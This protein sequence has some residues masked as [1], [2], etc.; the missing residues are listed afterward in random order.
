MVEIKFLKDLPLRH[1]NQNKTYISV[2]GGDIYYDK[3]GNRYA[4]IT[5]KNHRRSPLFALQISYREYSGEGKLIKDGEFYAPYMFETYGEFVNETPIPIDPQTEAL[6]VYVNKAIFDRDRFDN[7]RLKPFKEIDYIQE[8]KQAPKKRWDSK[9]DFDFG[10]VASTP[11]PQE[12]PQQE[13]VKEEEPKVPFSEELKIT[14]EEVIPSEPVA[15]EALVG[16]DAP[17]K[18]EEAAP[19]NATRG[20]FKPTKTWLYLIPVGIIVVVA[21]VAIVVSTMVTK[22]A[23]ENFNNTLPE[24]YFDIAKFIR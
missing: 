1:V 2:L 8:P 11:R 10:K 6:E 17:A 19:V 23:V 22:G 7:D 13:E 24:Y 12:A 21:V 20:T 16:D 3:D 15:G 9:S 18:A 5:F 4:F 14:G